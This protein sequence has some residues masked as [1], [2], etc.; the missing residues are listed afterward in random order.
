MLE[1]GVPTLSRGDALEKDRQPAPV[2]LGFPCEKTM[3][4]SFI[5]FPT[6]IFAMGVIIVSGVVGAFWAFFLGDKTDLNFIG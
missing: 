5:L 4:A 1:T 2:F 3:L 6:R